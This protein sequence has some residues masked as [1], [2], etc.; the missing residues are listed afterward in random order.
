MTTPP[1]ATTDDPRDIARAYISRMTREVPDQYL[2]AISIKDLV[3]DVLAAAGRHA[4]HL[5]R[6]RRDEEGTPYRIGGGIARHADDAGPGHDGDLYAA[7]HTSPDGVRLAISRDWTT[8][9]TLVGAPVNP[10]TL[11]IFTLALLAACDDAERQAA[12]ATPAAP[13]A[14]SW[15]LDGQAPDTAT[16]EGQ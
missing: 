12:E 3:R 13:V 14:P 1:T 10:A 16:A 6:H 4:L 7:I 15:D 2:V 5:P 11:R 9:E 8:D